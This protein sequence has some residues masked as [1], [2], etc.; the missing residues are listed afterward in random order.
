MK[1]KAQIQDYLISQPPQKRGDIELLHARILELYPDC[2]L[3]YFDGKNDKGKI[4]ANPNIGYGLQK[5][6][7]TDGNTKDCYKIG[8]SSNTIG[9]SIYI[10]TIKDKNYLPHTYSK[11]IGKASVSGY[12]IKFKKLSDIHL[13]ILEAAIQDG[14][15][16]EGR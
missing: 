10:M 6:K 1:L 4:I 15:N 13:D 11:T 12:C 14:F 16:R 9:I 5:I 2:Q 7:Y 8:I 3:W